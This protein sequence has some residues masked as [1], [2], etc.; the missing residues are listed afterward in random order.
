[1]IAMHRLLPHAVGPLA[2]DLDGEQRRATAADESRHVVPV[3]VSGDH[4]G[5]EHRHSQPAELVDAPFTDLSFLVALPVEHVV[6]LD[7]R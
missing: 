7:L 6:E 5:E 3:D 2:R 4:L 1:M